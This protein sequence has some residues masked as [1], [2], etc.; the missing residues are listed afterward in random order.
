[1]C[2]SS[3]VRCSL[4]ANKT[5]LGGGDNLPTLLLLSPSP[6][7][8][9]K[10]W[11]WGSI[12]GG[13]RARGKG[14]DDT[15]G[16][17]TMETAV[18]RVTVL[19][20]AP[21]DTSHRHHLYIMRDGSICT[22]D[23][24][25][26]SWS[27]SLH[28]MERLGGDSDTSAC[29]WW[30]NNDMFPSESAGWSN[31]KLVVVY[32]EGENSTIARYDP[33]DWE[34]VSM[35]EWT[36]ASRTTIE[37]CLGLNSVSAP[38]SWWNWAQATPEEVLSYLQRIP[39]SELN[40]APGLPLHSLVN[41][42]ELFKSSPDTLEDW[43]EA[44][45]PWASIEAWKHIGYSATQAR[46]FCHAYD[47]AVS[48][49]SRRFPAEILGSM[50]YFTP[51]PLATSFAE[52][53]IGFDRAMGLLDWAPQ[54]IYPDWPGAA[55]KAMGPLLEGVPVTWAKEALLSI[56]AAGFLPALQ[57]QELAFQL[58]AEIPHRLSQDGDPQTWNPNWCW[59]EGGQSLSAESETMQ[60]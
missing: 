16:V 20:H 7:V 15:E 59:P 38:A 48:T 10:D 55:E 23:H 51:G 8:P 14:H 30:K 12:M 57:R 17:N 44:G 1:M 32:G 46:D 45:Q 52:A 2:P 28:I 49:L 43:I 26:E 37:K 42:I 54:V 47:K 39:Y 6:Q 29:V 4:R 41:I 19:C 5:H 21:D 27:R 34:I 33:N 50:V 56:P 40:G 53:G 25:D 18:Y 22:P 58:A 9:H 60:S 35:S 11:Y 36:V 24:D 3:L 31:G 13:A